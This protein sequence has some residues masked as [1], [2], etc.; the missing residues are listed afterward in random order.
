MLEME[1]PYT[2]PV[3]LIESEKI[4]NG[5]VFLVS[6]IN[7]AS[8]WDHLVATVSSERLDQMNLWV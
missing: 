5:M 8:S 3:Y 4:Y 7:C 2:E 6:F 1:P